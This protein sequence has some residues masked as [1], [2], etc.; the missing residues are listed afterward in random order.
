MEIPVAI[1]PLNVL[2][3]FMAGDPAIK[4]AR[5]TRR[6]C[7]TPLAAHIRHHARRDIRGISQKGAQKA[8]RPELE[9]QS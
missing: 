1:A 3:M 8:Y 9:G 4:I 6:V 7:H 5:Y 2:G